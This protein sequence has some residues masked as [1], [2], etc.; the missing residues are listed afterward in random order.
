MSPF[1]NTVWE[2]L[3]SEA[4]LEEVCHWKGLE[5]KDSCHFQFALSAS[6]LIYELSAIYSSC[7]SCLVPPPCQPS[8]TLIF[9]NQNPNDLGH[10]ILLQPQ[11]RQNKKVKV[12]LEKI[13]CWIHKIKAFIT[14]E[15]G[16]AYLKFTNMGNCVLISIQNIF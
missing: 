8:Q 5:L 15:K 6:C 11:K 7:H 4:L 12:K 9:W 16:F 14:D 1:G 10:G 2:C 13:I 3:G